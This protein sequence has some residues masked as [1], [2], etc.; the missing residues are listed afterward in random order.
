MPT[1][2]PTDLIDLLRTARS[3]AVLTG[4]GTSAES[5]I[6]TF[7]DAQTGLWAK[8]DP[9]ELATPEA[10]QEN[11]QLV[12]DW[13]R[14]RR[15][16]TTQAKPNPGHFALAAMEK[17]FERM[18][19][20]TQNVDGL[21]SRAGSRNI[22]ELHGNL[23]RLR[24]TNSLCHSKPCAW[25]DTVELPH[26]QK[27]GALLRPDIVWFGEA[28]PHQALQSAIRASRACEVFFSIGTSGVVEPAASLPYV[29]LRAGAVIVEINPQPTPLSVHTRYCF[30]QPSGEALPTILEAV[31][32]K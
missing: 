17:H 5:G 19:L 29:A 6:P 15:S 28:L 31:W 2:V 23:T 1:E 27:C 18:V 21:H 7:R 22:I 11:P 32:G 20:I 9:H 16:L 30:T 13:Y 3:V 10:F 26:C 12:I 14:W 25:P 4:A 8:Y 24:C